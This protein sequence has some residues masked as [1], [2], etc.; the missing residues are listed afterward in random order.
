MCAFCVDKPDFAIL[1]P[2]FFLGAVAG[3]LVAG[4]F[5]DFYI[6]LLQH[7]VLIR[8]STLLLHFASTTE[9]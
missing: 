5:Y 3:R 7:P 4:I 8:S 9:L 1:K 2:S 6:S